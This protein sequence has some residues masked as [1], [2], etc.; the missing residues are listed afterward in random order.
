MRRR[1]IV[2]LTMAATGVLWA[3]AGPA[4]AGAG[5]HGTPTDDTGTVVAMEANC[6]SPTVLRISPGD[7]V[8]WRND[9]P[10]AHT[11][12][13]VGSLWGDPADR[14]PGER[15]SY[16][17]EGNGVYVYSCIL[18]PGMVG[19]V[20]VG[21]GTGNAGV[22]PAAAMT[23]VAPSDLDRTAAGAASASGDGRIGWL[24]VG[25]AVVVGIAV[26][27]LVVLGSTKGSRA[28]RLA[29]SA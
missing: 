9:D 6:F 1:T 10:V 5:C 23:A 7:D 18:H 17:F 15:I 28:R 3:T 20:V 11:V 21:D 4:S 2:L 29:S 22:E 19:A 14:M 25:L 12:T 16:T 26:G 27:A 13:G 8:T 24:S